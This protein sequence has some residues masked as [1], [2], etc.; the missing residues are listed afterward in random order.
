MTQSSSRKDEVV[1]YIAT[2]F[3]ETMANLRWRDKYYSM[4]IDRMLANVFQLN[5]CQQK[6]W[7]GTEPYPDLLSSLYSKPSI[8]TIDSSLASGLLSSTRRVRHRRSL[9][10]PISTS[11]TSVSHFEAPM[12]ELLAERKDFDK[13]SHCEQEFKRGQDQKRNFRRHFKTHF[14][15]PVLFECPVEDCDR[16]YTSQFNCDRH[17]GQKHSR[18]IGLLDHLSPENAIE[19]GSRTQVQG[20][21]RSQSH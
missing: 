20:R 16:T 15:E 10:S 11:G 9:A 4:S 1:Q 8:S 6:S 2:L 18:S 13:C 7:K 12:E 14:Q 19:G 3:D 21:S 5:I 17:F